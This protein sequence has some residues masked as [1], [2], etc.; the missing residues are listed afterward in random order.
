M[1]TKGGLFPTR[2]KTYDFTLKFTNTGVYIVLKNIATH[3]LGL[4]VNISQL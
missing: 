1:H 4:P 2:L 3:S